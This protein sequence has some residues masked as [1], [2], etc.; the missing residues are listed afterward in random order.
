MARTK[1][2]AC[3]TSALGGKAPRKAVGKSRVTKPSGHYR[4][5]VIALREIRKY[6]KSTKLLIAKRPFQRYVKQICAEQKVGFRFQSAAIEA[7]Q[8]STSSQT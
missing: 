5:E 3:K 8:V 2:V 6:Q 1:Q 7:L 4:P